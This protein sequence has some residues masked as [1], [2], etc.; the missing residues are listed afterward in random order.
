MKYITTKIP[1]LIILEPKV[2]ADERGFFMESFNQRD[3]ETAVG[4]PV[5]FVQDNHSK[6]VK[7]VL[8]GM[9]Y[10]NEPH[11]QGKLVRCIVGEVYDVAVDIRR[12]SPT[13]GQWLGVILSAE[14]KRQLW[15]PSGFAHGFLVKSEIAE[16]TYKTTNYYEPRSESAIAWNDPDLSINW[17]ANERELILSGKDKLAN[18]FQ[19]IIKAIK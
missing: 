11:S 16:F 2:Y 7:N 1:G 18:S 4:H 9:H 13:F 17:P 3:F 10:Q 19:N 8:R 12:S 5:D 6:S 14:N 15:I